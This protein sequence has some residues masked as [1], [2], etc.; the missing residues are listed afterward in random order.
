MEN[1]ITVVALQANEHPLNALTDSCC[2]NRCQFSFTDIQK[3]YTDGNSLEG[4]PTVFVIA[5]NETW[6]G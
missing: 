3:I 5:D 2:E 6:T 1:M 4:M